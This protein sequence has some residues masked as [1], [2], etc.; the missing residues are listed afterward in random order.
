MR[1]RDQFLKLIEKLY[2]SAE[3]ADLWPTAVQECVQFTAASVGLLFAYKHDQPFNLAILHGLDQSILKPY[4]A[5]FTALDNQLQ[6]LIRHPPGTILA[7]AA[8][9]GGPAFYE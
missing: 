3:D 7:G 9:N 8:L 4:Q 6:L 2:A 5:H 1:Q